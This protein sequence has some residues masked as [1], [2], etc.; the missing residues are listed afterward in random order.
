[1]KAENTIILYL[2]DHGAQ[3]SRGKCSNYEAALRVPLII[4]WPGHATPGIRKS[5]LVSVIDLLPTLLDVSGIDIPELLPRKSLIPLLLN[6]KDATGHDYIFADG[7]GSAAFFYFPKR[8]VRD[9]RYK[10]IYN[11]LQD[12]ENPKF[13]QYAEQMGAHFAGGTKLSEIESA[14][15][16]VQRAYQTWRTP[17]TYELYDLQEDPLEFNNLSSNPQY[18]D[19]MGSLINELNKW[20][21]D[22]GDPL[23][24]PEKLARYTRE[25][26]SVANSY[27]RNSYARDPEFQWKYPGYFYENDTPE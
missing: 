21:T 6:K 15:L 16:E 12:R 14:S 3:F 19:I 23:A 4:K 13:M 24:D 2:G 17:P 27:S 11:L 20:Q 9:S 22:T 7:S 10:L 1:G 8:S 5:D 26:D 25:V 18:G